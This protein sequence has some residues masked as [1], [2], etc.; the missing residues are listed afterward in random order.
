RILD[1]LARYR[2]L[3]LEYMI[4]TNRADKARLEKAMGEIE[5]S[6]GVGLAE[7]RRFLLQEEE[8]EAFGELE[9]AWARYVDASRNRFLP[10]TRDSNT[11]T[12]QPAFTRLNPMHDRLVS[13]GERLAGLNAAAAHDAMGVVQATHR[14]SRTFIVIDTLF[15]VLL[16]A[17][18]GLGLAAT[19]AHR[20]GSLS[21][22][23][24]RVAAGDLDRAVEVSGSDELSHLAENFNRMVAS[25]RYKRTALE[26]RHLELEASLDKQRRLTEDLVRREQA[27]EAADRARAEAEAR[28]AAKSLFLATMSHELRTPL[29]AILGFVQLMT[30]DARAR[31]DAAALADLGRIEAAGKHLLTVIDNVL[32]FS[33]IEQGKMD[34]ELSRCELSALVGEVVEIVEPLARKNGNRLLLDLPEAAGSLESDAAKLRQVLF[35][36]L[37][38]AVKFTLDGEV[39]LRLRRYEEDG[40]EWVEIAVSDTGVGIAPEHLDRIFRPFHQAESSVRRRFGGTGLGLVVSRQ[41]CQ[42]LGG[43][44]DVESEPGEGSTFTVRLP[45]DPP[46]SALSES[47]AQRRIGHSRDAVST[48][49]ADP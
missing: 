33:K 37:S 13:A 36:L 7:Q 10:A 4:Y 38:N 28:D 30:F 1:L 18:V 41:L 44:V 3:Q 20:V 17:A 34:V 48:D 35:N 26:E 47:G 24:R 49:A 27:E 25:L 32:D 22:A 39:R 23:T 31:D 9:T 8:V 46:I 5:A 11:G 42:L 14:S 40:E 29:N 16:S 43:D 15:S 21:S 2:T 6:V 19:L 12:V 45:V